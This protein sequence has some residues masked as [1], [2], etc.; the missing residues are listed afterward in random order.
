MVM[1]ANDTGILGVLYPS[2][3]VLD[4]EVWQCRDARV[5]EAP[6]YRV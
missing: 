6:Y 5:M 4:L 3:E 2:L 1:G